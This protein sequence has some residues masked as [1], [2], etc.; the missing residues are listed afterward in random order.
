MAL[1]E[2]HGSP[3]RGVDRRAEKRVKVLVD[4][5]AVNTTF[6]GARLSEGENVLTIPES[7]LAELEAQ[8]EDA[9]W[10]PVTERYEDAVKEWCYAPDGE[11][12]RDESTIAYNMSKA[13]VDQYR[14]EPRRFKRV[15]VLEKNIDPP[16]STS[17]KMAVTLMDRLS[18][19]Q[20]GQK[21]RGRKSSGGS[22]E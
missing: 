17:D 2:N 14:R 19:A 1:V 22:T 9:D 15:E 6:H 16:M 21:S 5:R 11:K 12:I 20:S 10:G 4:A 13:F 3:R 18:A 8:V 7:L